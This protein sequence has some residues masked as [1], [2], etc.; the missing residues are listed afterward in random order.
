VGVGEVAR[1]RFKVNGIY[2]LMSMAIVMVIKHLLRNLFKSSETVLKVIKSTNP[3]S[4][5]SMVNLVKIHSSKGKLQP[6]PEDRN[7]L[8]DL[9]DGLAEDLKSW[10]LE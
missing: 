1:K 6:E 4:L 8:M 7:K 9:M 2:E 3:G 10:R 5:T